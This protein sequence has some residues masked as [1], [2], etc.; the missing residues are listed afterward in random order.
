M[1]DTRSVVRIRDQ[2]GRPDETDGIFQVFN[3][4]VDVQ[5]QPLEVYKRDVLGYTIWGAFNWGEAN[6]QE[7]GVADALWDDAVWDGSNWGDELTNPMVLQ[8]VAN[9]FDT[10]IEKFTTDRF[11]NPDFSSNVTW[12]NS[13]NGL[14]FGGS[15]GTATSR[16]FYKGEDNMLRVLTSVF[17]DGTGANNL[18]LQ[19]QSN[20]DGDWYNVN[21]NGETSIKP[22]TELIFRMVG[23]ETTVKDLRIKYYRE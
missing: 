23:S 21:I 20:N 19:M 9:A 3:T 13:S 2:L 16:C 18:Q 10:Y 12:T 11:K 5:L 7:E 14:V 17:A 22:S 8:W 15:T 4:E 6:W 1:T